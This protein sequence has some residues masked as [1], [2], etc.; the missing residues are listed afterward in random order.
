MAI[1]PSFHSPTNYFRVPEQMQA[2]TTEHVRAPAEPA[3]PE[4]PGTGNGP[5]APER[6][7]ASYRADLLRKLE[8]R[9]AQDYGPRGNPE[10]FIVDAPFAYDDFLKS[11]PVLASIP[12]SSHGREIAIVGAG[13]AGLYAARELAKMGLRPVIFEAAE[14]AGGRLDSRAMGKPLSQDSAGGFAE[15]GAMR[16]PTGGRAFNTVLKL[17][18]IVRGD[19]QNKSLIFP[20]PGTVNTLLYV[21]GKQIWWKAGQPI[22]DAGLER[23]RQEFGKAFGDLL[24]P[25]RAARA[26]KDADGFIRE[27]HALASRFDGLSFRQGVEKMMPN[28]GKDELAMFGAVGIGS[29]G[30][31]PL[32]SLSMLE[33]LRVEANNY[34]SKQKPLLGGSDQVIDHLLAAPY[35]SAADAAGEERSLNDGRSAEVR[36][37]TKVTG[38]EKR[39]GGKVAVTFVDLADVAQ[40]VATREFD[41]AIVA[42]T[43]RAMEQMGLC[44][45][46]AD[47]VTA[48]VRDAI[49]TVHMAAATKT[50]ISVKEKFWEGRDDIPQNIQTDRQP[51]GTYA[52]S[53]PGTN[54]GVVCL[55][56]AWEDK[57]IKDSA[58]S[59]PDRIVGQLRTIGEASPE[60]LRELV[61]N[62]PLEDNPFAAML[63]QQ[64]ALNDGQLVDFARALVGSDAVRHVD[65]QNEPLHGGAFKLVYPD[66]EDANKQ[67]FYAAF[68]REQVANT[69]V[70][71]AGDG[72]SFSGGWADGAIHTAVNAV[73]AMAVK[74]GGELPANS[75]L[76]VLS[77]DDAPGRRE[78]AVSARA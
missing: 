20:N 67:L 3:E 55:N 78:G 41:G 14:R 8:E 22:S 28:W 52:L 59:V 1:A 71:L 76:D 45:A 9:H 57:A 35:E 4:L 36:M 43:T 7:E 33:I 61:R 5:R 51:H 11:H 24:A 48:P 17:M 26:N 47:L 70:V 75:P 6:A 49:A 13:L 69:G 42:T 66:Q 18:G 62:A 50:F 12:P 40:P 21:D 25:L 39:D 16:F 72:V 38:L 29:G 54:E 10:K 77:I 2:T 63:E 60:F 23:V 65:W 44:S 31:G 30:F 53:Y 74:L 15:L 37:Q 34:E 73:Q 64:E 68:D 58:Q 46:Q 27:W 19:A 32:Y 56:Y